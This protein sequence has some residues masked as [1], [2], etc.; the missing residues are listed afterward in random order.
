MKPKQGSGHREGKI[1]KVH[2]S[3][4][5]EG[6]LKRPAGGHHGPFQLLVGH[7]HHHV[8]RSQPQKRRRKARKE[9]PD[10]GKE[11]LC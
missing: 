8:P 11:L 10:R 3:G 1:C 6:G 2:P 9:R 7:E 4:G 5:S